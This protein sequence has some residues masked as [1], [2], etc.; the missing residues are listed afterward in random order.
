VIGALSQLPP[1]GIQPS[2]RRLVEI[3][4]VANG[5]IGIL[6]SSLKMLGRYYSALH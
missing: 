1:N 6:I 3:P 2:I 5:M 4:W